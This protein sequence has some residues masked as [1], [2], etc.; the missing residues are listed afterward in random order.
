MID[1]KYALM[2]AFAL[3]AVVV[4]VV[5]YHKEEDKEEDKEETFA[6]LERTFYSDRDRKGAATTV[7]FGQT[8]VLHDGKWRVWSCAC[9][10][11]VIKVT[12]AGLPH[13]LFLKGGRID[14]LPAALGG[15]PA[16]ENYTAIFNSGRT[17][18]VEL[19][20]MNVAQV[21]VANGLS[22]CIASHTYDKDTC[23]TEFAVI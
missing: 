14:N 17:I 11:T 8:V 10:D 12:A 1:K 9:P 5:L 22:H 18:S 7:K 21:E 13:V 6:G 3:I 4:L 2:G 20:P 16:H 19:V 23:A 15:L